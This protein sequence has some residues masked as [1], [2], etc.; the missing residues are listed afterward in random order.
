VEREFL[1]VP[2]REPDPQQLGTGRVQTNARVGEGQS[3]VAVG[4]VLEAVVRGDV[5]G[6]VEQRGVDAE[7]GLRPPGLPRRR[8]RDLRVEVLA[9]APGR[10]QALEHRAVFE[11]CCG[12]LVVDL[13]DGQRLRVG[14]RPLREFGE[15]RVRRGRRTT[16]GEQAFRVPRPRRVAVRVSRPGQDLDRATARVLR[17]ADHDLH[18]HAGTR[19]DDQRRLEDELF[20]FVEPD[21]VRRPDRRLDECGARDQHRAHHRVVGEPGVSTQGEGAGQDEVVG[22]GDGQCGVEEWVAE[23]VLA[24]VLLGAS[25]Q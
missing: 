3:V 23:G 2:H 11:A 16:A 6:G 12:Q 20:E 8:Q 13:V 10:A 17:L 5:Q 9:V 25:S 24:R 4:A 15:R 19:R 7:S 18:L 21:L 14:R 1:L 22:C